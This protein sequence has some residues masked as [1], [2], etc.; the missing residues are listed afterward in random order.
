MVSAACP[1]NLLEGSQASVVLPAGRVHKAVSCP[2]RRPPAPVRTAVGP[3]RL[4]PRSAEAAPGPRPHAGRA[5]CGLS[6]PPGSR[7][8][9]GARWPTWKGTSSAAGRWCVR[10]ASRCR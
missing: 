7:S 3:P 1:G 2:V 5:C 10:G 6:V 8:C 4:C 9:A